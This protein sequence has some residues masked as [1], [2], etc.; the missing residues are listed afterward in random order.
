MKHT[1]KTRPEYFQPAWVGSKTFEIR[2]NDRK[3]A[4]HDEIVLEEIEGADHEYTGRTIEG[5]IEYITDFEQKP[6]YVVFSY[7]VTFQTE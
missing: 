4:V 1:L 7:R 6:G 5:V 2:N 3:F